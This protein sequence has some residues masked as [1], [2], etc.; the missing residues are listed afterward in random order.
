MK[1]RRLAVL[2]ML[3]AIN[4]ALSV[5]TPV[6]V[7]NFKFTFEAFPILVSAF[8][9][10]GNEGFIV[11]ALGSTIYQVLFSG[12]AITL[13][14][15]LWIVPH[16][17]SGYLVGTYASKKNHDLSTKEIIFISVVSAFLV[18]SLNTCALYI[19]AKV[20]GYYSTKLVFGTLPLKFIAGG[21]LAVIYSLVMPTL[22]KQIKKM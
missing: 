3:I 17:L 7:M 10:G 19:D 6:K 5:L 13:T 9:F 14:T 16:A 15:P 1:T 12:Y 22:V 4:V 8:M 2:S 20:Y 18:T 11:G 21:M